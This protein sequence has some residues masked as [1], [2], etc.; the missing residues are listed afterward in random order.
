[1]KKLITLIAGLLLVTLPV[2]LAGCDDSDKEIYNDGRLVTDVVIPTSM[3]VY[4]GM[5][6]SVS[7]YGFA[8]G[9]AIALRAGEDLPAATTVA[10]EKLLTFVIPDGA[11][12][13]TVYKVVLN[14]AQDYQVL[15][16]SRM[17]VQLAIDVDLGKTISGNWGGDAVIRGRG[18]MATDKLFLEQGGGK[19]EAPVKG[20]DDSSLTFTIPQNAA[21]GDCVTPNRMEGIVPGTEVYRNYDHRFNQ[22]LARSRTRRVIPASVLVEATAGGVRFSYTDCEGVTASAARSVAL[23]RAKNAAANTAALRTQAV[24]GGDTVFAVRGAEVRGGDWF[25]PVSL[26]AELRREGLDALSKARSERGIGHRILPEGRAEYPAECLSAEENVTNRLAE[27]FYRD[28][29]VGRI[30]RGLDL[31]AS[32]AGRRVMRSAYCIRREIGECLKEHPRLRGEL[33][34]ERGGSRYRLEFDCDRCEMSL[35][36]CTKTK[37]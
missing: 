25:V 9:D 11:A 2:G 17:T 18:F 6:V 30:E 36:D 16:S 32:T 37:L 20:A 14:R 26:A 4:R 12:D 13:Q 24:K 34:L 31:A 5:E 22:L 19:F 8:Q 29:G 1:M 21:D 3:T 35:V 33:W 15:G 23:E 27:A 7:G 10:S 28:H